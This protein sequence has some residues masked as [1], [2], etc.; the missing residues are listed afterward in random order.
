MAAVK[1]NQRPFPLCSITLRY[2][3]KNLFN[4]SKLDV[5]I[6][7]DIFDNYRCSSVCLYVCVIL[8]SS[9]HLRR[10]IKMESDLHFYNFLF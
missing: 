6:K 7:S 3:I 2:T 1:G 10:W 4:N 8:D 9:V 5:D